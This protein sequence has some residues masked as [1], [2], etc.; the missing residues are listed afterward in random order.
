MEG[1]TE[2]DRGGDEEEE[3]EEEEDGGSR[4]KRSCLARTTMYLRRKNKVF[5]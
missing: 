3:E 1:R 2:G 4:G 5:A